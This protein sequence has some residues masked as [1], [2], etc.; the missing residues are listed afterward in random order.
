MLNVLILCTG[1]SAR[2]IMAEAWLAHL[3]AGR[4]QAFSAGSKPAG[5]PHPQALAQIARFAPQLATHP[6]RSKS[7]LEFAEPT[8]PQMDIV[9][10]VC[11]N[12]AGETCPLWPGSPVSAH[13]GFEDPAAADPAQQAVAFAAISAQIEAR[14]RAMLAL[15]LEQMDA[16]ARQLALRQ[17][18]QQTPAAESVA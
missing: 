8:A 11:S 10:T 15:P 17:L 13:W 3:G 7:W 9:I 1:N 5:Q 12:A 14:I 4:F 6:W 16:P 18:A 2:S